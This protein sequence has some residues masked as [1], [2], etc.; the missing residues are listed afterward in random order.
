MQPWFKFEK[1]DS[2]AILFAKNVSQDYYVIYYKPFPY[3]F[4]GF[5]LM[6][7]LYQSFDVLDSFQVINEFIFPG[8]FRVKIILLTE[9]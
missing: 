3:G 1:Q 8:A 7:F 6:Y 4:K 9:S 5:L 2:F